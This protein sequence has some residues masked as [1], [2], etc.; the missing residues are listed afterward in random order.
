LQLTRGK[1]ETMAAVVCGVRNFG[2]F[3]ELPDSLM[4][5]LVHVSRLEDDFYQY[6]ERLERLVGRGTKRIIKIGD[7]LNVQVERVD[8][9]KRQI[10]FRVIP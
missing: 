4:Q 9:V 8:L 5:G 7:K 3:V 10:D 1:L 2:F 6:D